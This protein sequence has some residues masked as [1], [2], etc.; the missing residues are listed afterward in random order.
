MNRKLAIAAV[1]L[2]CCA[3]MP[4]NAQRRA[5]APG[6][7]NAFIDNAAG[8]QQGNQ[9][10]DTNC[11]QC[12]GMG[13]NGGQVGPAITS[14]TNP[15]VVTNDGQVYN[16]IKNG[17]PGTVMPSFTGKLSDDDMLKVTAYL[18]ATRGMAIN[19]PTAGDTAHGKLVFSGKGQCSS[20]H[21]INGVGGISGPD[22]S[23]IAS[24]RRTNSIID[25]LTKPMHHVYGSGGAHLRQLPTMDTYPAVRV[26]QANGKVLTGVLMNEDDF[27]VEIMGDDQQLHLLDRA[28]L[29]SVSVDGKS[30][31]PTDYDKRLAPDEFKDL[32]AYLTRQGTKS[33]PAAAAGRGAPP[34]AD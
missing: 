11:S 8:V 16:F 13:G 22:L 1:I 18:H 34:P 10:Y 17:V 29:R 2:A 31:M 24:N 32:L 12:H 21:M 23:Q 6:P 20:C 9:L 5:P 33:G 7:A 3:A 4:A 30:P 19:N 14:G 27:A 15:D 26:T 25:A 28:K